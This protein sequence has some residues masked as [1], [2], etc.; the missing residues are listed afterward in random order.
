MHA[1]ELDDLQN[2]YINLLTTIIENGRRCAPRGVPTIDLGP[3]TITLRNPEHCTPVGIGRDL[4]ITIASAET[5]HLTAGISDAMQ[6]RSVAP[7]FSRFT[8]EDRLRGAYGPRLHDQMPQVLERLCKDSD[9]RQAVAMIWRSNELEDDANLDVPC[10]VSLMFRVEDGMLN[11]LT[12]MRSNDAFLGVPYDFT[13][14]T[15]FQATIAWALGGIRVG[16]YEHVAWSMHVYERDLE[17]IK[18]LEPTKVPQLTPVPAFGPGRYDSNPGER[19]LRT[20]LNRWSRARHMAKIAMYDTPSKS[21]LNESAKWHQEQLRDHLSGGLYCS[22]CHYVLPRTVQHFWALGRENQWK[23]RCRQCVK[24]QVESRPSQTDER[25]F[26]LRC[27]KYGVTPEWYFEQLRIQ[28]GV[29]AICHQVP[30]NG[31]YRDFVIDHDHLTNKVRGLLC[32][33]C[34]QAIGLL[35]DD[36]RRATNIITYLM[37]ERS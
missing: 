23:S 35:Q 7:V 26:A 30:D 27:M 24:T 1:V 13:M 28:N 6:M 36:S 25:R 17:A 14:F 12:T 3:T 4:N 32:S 20:V 37:K 34:N 31:R 10:T 15:R 5:T 18:R 29:C 9:T 33:N 16:T 19:D 22:H 11:M 8:N 21:Y 2:G